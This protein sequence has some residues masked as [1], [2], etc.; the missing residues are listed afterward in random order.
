MAVLLQVLTGLK[1]HLMLPLLVVNSAAVCHCYPLL[2]TALPPL[3]LLTLTMYALLPPPTLML[4]M[5]PPLLLPVPAKA[6][7]L[8][9]L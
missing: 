4:M 3:L 7:L 2:L 1:L 8:P 5:L 6:L 9:L